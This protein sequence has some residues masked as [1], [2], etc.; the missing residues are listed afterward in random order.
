M[1]SIIKCLFCIFLGIFWLIIFWVNFFVI[2]VFLIFGLLIKIGLFLVWWFKIW[3][4]W[5]ILVLWLIIG[6]KFCFCVNLVK[7]FVKEFNVGVFCGVFLFWLFWWCCVLLGLEMFIFFNNNWCILDKF[8]FKFIKIL[9]VKI[10]LFFNKFN[11]KCLVLIFW[12][13]KCFVLFLV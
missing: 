8:N 5:W 10:F 7:F 6:F 2:V 1:F 3:I 4:K 13:F 11:N 12:V 9:D